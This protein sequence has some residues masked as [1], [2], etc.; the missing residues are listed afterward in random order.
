MKALPFVLYLL[1]AGVAAAAETPGQF[2]VIVNSE[3]PAASASRPTIAGLFL[4]RM[5]KWQNGLKSQPVDLAESSET[6]EAFSRRILGRRTAEVEQY[7]QTAI[8]SGRDIPPPK[9][10]SESE[11]VAYVAQHPG[12]IGYVSR[13]TPLVSG[14]KALHLLEK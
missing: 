12:A 9:K 4:K 8:F 1:L 7:W 10:A 13:T 3:N 11:V 5:G 6:R 14:V 2:V